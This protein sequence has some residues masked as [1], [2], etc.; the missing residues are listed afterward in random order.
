MVCCGYWGREH[1]GESYQASIPRTRRAIAGSNSGY[2]TANWILRLLAPELQARGQ[3]PL[4][5]GFIDASFTGA[6]K[7]GSRLVLPN[8]AKAPRSSPSA[9]IPVFLS[10]L[11][12]KALRRTKASSSKKSSGKASSTNF[13]ND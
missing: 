5:E 1:S 10:P 9:L 13:R 2:A 8:A 7:G 12:S 6:K 3:L 11:V 4:G